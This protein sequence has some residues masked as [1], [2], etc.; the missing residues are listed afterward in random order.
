MVGFDHVV[1]C[2][3]GFMG[4]L[5]DTSSHSFGNSQGLRTLGALGAWAS[6]VLKRSLPPPTAGMLHRAPIWVLDFTI[7]ISDSLAVSVYK[8]LVFS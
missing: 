8:F 5:L 7:Y 6:K 4:Q 1:T 2:K 3:R